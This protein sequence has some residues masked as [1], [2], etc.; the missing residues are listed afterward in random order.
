MQPDG[1]LWYVRFFLGICES[2]H[3]YLGTPDG[4]G[5]E[6]VWSD[7]WWVQAGS[8]GELP[9]SLRGTHLYRFAAGDVA[10]GGALRGQICR[11]F[12]QIC[13]ELHT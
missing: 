3:P 4:D 12:E 10:T 1:D 11:D 2:D 7:C 13:K 8:K 5:Y 9:P 6:E